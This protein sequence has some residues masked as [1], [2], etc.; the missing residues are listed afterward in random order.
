MT[1]ADAKEEI[2]ELLVDDYYKGPKKD[3]E[4]PG[5]IWE[6]KKKVDGIPFYIKIKIVEENGQSILK[7][8]GFHDDD[9]V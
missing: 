8:L 6:F 1:I 4:R 5:E 2:L 9:F 3:F 7:C